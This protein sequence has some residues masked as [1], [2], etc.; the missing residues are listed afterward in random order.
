MDLSF[1]VYGLGAEHFGR[2]LRRN[3]RERRRD[4]LGTMLGPCCFRVLAGLFEWVVLKLC[5]Q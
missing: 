1:G 4:D 5:M 2:L 3:T